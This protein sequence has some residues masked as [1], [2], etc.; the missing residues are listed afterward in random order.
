MKKKI[1]VLVTQ[2]FGELDVLFPIFS[3][4]ST[5]EDVDIELVFTVNAIYEKF[6]QNDFYQFFVG[7]Y[8]IKSSLFIFYKFIK[9]ND[10]SL[11]EKGIGGFKNSIIFLINMFKTALLLQKITLN[12]YYMHE[13]TNQLTSTWILYLFN[14]LFKKKIIV[15]H[16][17]HSINIYV[18]LDLAI[19]KS[20]YAGKVKML[21]FHKDTT[22][23]WSSKGFEN[24][25]IIGYPK[26]Y[27]EWKELNKNYA[28]KT[29]I[30]SKFVLIYSRPVHEYY[31]DKDKYA[32]LLISSCNAVQSNLEGVSIIIKPH[33][34]ESMGFM[35][36]LLNDA[37]I[38]NFS[39][40]YDSSLLY[41]NSCILVISFWTSAIL[42][43]LSINVPAI[44][45]YIE[46]N[47]FRE[48]EPYGSIYKNIGIVA[49][50]NSDD[51]D[52][53]I[54]DFDEIKRINKKVYKNLGSYSNVQFL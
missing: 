19:K 29:E 28:K 53:I 42:G 31:M 33:P 15:Y 45:Y 9:L 12:R 38:I 13:S 14:Y 51:L 32:E 43:A 10:L 5:K 22:E 4:L 21:A 17:G 3:K 41:S 24:Q 47:K 37:H 30:K 25:H 6:K 34:R 1:L 23:H 40:N 44:E 26:F 27:P 39:I 8:K 49:V 7:K 16:H 46:A 50:N 2:S 36:K 11:V 18:P 52:K 20:K 35:K 48:L 54:G